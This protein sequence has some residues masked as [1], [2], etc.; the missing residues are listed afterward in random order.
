M[1]SLHRA[2]K[3]GNKIASTLPNPYTSL[4]NRSI[5]LRRGE[6]TLIA[7]QPGAG[8]STVALHWAWKA[9]RPTLYFCADTSEA[10]MQLRLAAMI[11]D[12]DQSLVEPLMEDTTW[13]ASVLSQAN[14][15][16]WSFE[17]A[18]SLQDIE[19]EVDAFSELYGQFPELIV[20]DNLI[21]CT[22][23][24]GDEWNSL[25]SLLRELKWWARET[26]ASVLCLHHTSEGTAGNPAPPRNAIMGKLAQTPAL[27]LTVTNSQPGFLGVCPVKNRWGQ[28]DPS[29][30]NVSWL[31]YEPA[32]MHIGD[33]ET[34]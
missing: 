34:R 6:V 19:L 28:A 23:S 5:Q 16:R 20:I 32:R 27:I 2:V 12:T 14:N 8:K 21:D 9:Q 15:I 17:S 29:G 13:A 22:H 31:V 11:T 24:D 30:A 33:M 26:N 10:S 25:R 1:R 3:A 4:A 7:G 18:P